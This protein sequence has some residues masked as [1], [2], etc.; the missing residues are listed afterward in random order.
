MEPSRFLVNGEWRSSETTRPVLNPYTRQQVRH[1]FQASPSD[2]SDAI[3]AASSAFELTKSLPAFKR[4]QILAEV[5]RRVEQHREE[6]ARLITEE[7]AKP[8]SLSRAEVER[9]I[10]TFTVA[11]EEAKR[12]EGKLIPLDLA[13]HS[14]GRFGLVRRFPLGPVAAITPFN[15]PINLV[16]HKVAPALAVGNTLVLKPSSNAPGVALRLASILEA[17]RVPSGAI[18]VVPCLANEGEQL[19]VDERIKLISFTGSPRVGWRLK[20]QAGKKK[21]V[22]ELGGNAGVIVD[23][24]TDLNSCVPRIAHGSYANAGQSCIAVQR[25]FVH[26]EIY[27]PFVDRF[28]D[29]SKRIPTGDPFDEKTVVGPMITEEAAVQ[30]KSWIGDAVST[31]AKVLCGGHRNGPMLD[32]TVL[33]NV[34]NQMKICSEEVF[35]PVVTIESFSSMEEVLSMVNDSKYGLQA[36][37]FTNDLKGAFLAFQ[38]LEVGGVIVNDFPTYRIDHMPYGGVKDSG[39]GREGVRYAM[40]E[41]TEIKLLVVN[42][43]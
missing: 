28:V 24:G 29:V 20:A 25:I 11:S 16:A 21:V 2:I 19:L 37:V 31:G 26:K 9:S 35:A 36:G 40:E 39:F 42:P 33:V 41:M 23:K 18:N 43:M 5:A 4:A 8:I 15:F 27:R 1:V 6:L 22:L 32:P 13:E 7:T 38:R 10:F 34:S 3:G 17:V 12:L 14:L 30:V